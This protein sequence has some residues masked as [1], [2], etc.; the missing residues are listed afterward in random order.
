[1]IAERRSITVAALGLPMPKLIIVMPS[2]V[3]LGIGRSGP[4]TSTPVSR[5]KCPR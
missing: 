2:A 1:M 5:A 3:A 4:T